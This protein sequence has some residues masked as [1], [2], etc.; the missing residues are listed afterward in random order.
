MTRREAEAFVRATA[1]DTVVSESKARE[2]F[3]ALFGRD[4]DPEDDAPCGIWSHCCA[5]V[6]AVKRRRV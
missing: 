2:V 3:A 4:P 6:A 1:E 5:A